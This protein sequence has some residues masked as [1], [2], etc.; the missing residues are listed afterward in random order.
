M[1]PIS[2]YVLAH[3]LV[4]AGYLGLA[5]HGWRS[6]TRPAAAEAVVPA[7]TVDRWLLP[8]LTVAHGA[9]LAQTMLGGGDFRFGFALALSATLWLTVAILWVETFFVPMR[10]LYPMVLPAA[11]LATVLPLV[12]ESVVIGAGAG[13]PAA[14]RLHLLVA[15]FANSLLTIAALHALLMAALDRRLHAGA[16]RAP[17][18]ESGLFRHAPPL[19]AMERLLFQLIAAGFVLLTATV[20]SGVFFSEQLFG[21]ALRFEHKTVFALAAWVVFGGLLLGRWGFGWRGRV[22]L[23]WTLIGFVMLLLAYVGSRFVIEVVLGR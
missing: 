12:F 18:G 1:G 14:F 20:I 19:L 9:L 10:M 21:R 17:A 8:V 5:W 4:A 15:I 7:S 2:F 23:R 22:A 6:L 11:A 16:A 3:L 13:N